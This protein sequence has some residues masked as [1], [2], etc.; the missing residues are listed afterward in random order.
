MMYSPSLPICTAIHHVI[1]FIMTRSGRAVGSPTRRMHQSLAVSWEVRRLGGQT[2]LPLHFQRNCKPL[3]NATKASKPIATMTRAEA[4]KSL[5]TYENESL[6]RDFFAKEW[7]ATRDLLETSLS[8]T[9]CS[10]LNLA[11]PGK[12]RLFS[13]PLFAEF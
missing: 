1:S 6:I 13:L 7:C 4:Q 12:A 3:V 9:V 11:W 8:H 5:A 2:A 10:N